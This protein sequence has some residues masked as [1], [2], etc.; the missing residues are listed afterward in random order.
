MDTMPTH[1]V[2][3]ARLIFQLPGGGRLE[4]VLDR[5][6]LSLGRAPDNDLV[7]DHPSISRHHARLLVTGEQVTV[8][9]LGS[10]NGIYADGERLAVNAPTLLT[11]KQAWYFGQVPVE[12][13]PPSLLPAEMPTMVSAHPVE[14]PIAP[15][16]PPPRYRRVPPSIGC[17]APSR[18]PRPPPDG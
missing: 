5:P 15:P 6:M 18:L 1:P 4:F 17:R 16:A 3:P 14:L 2:Q 13:I 9:D 10:S 8:E 12:I 11:T 7:V